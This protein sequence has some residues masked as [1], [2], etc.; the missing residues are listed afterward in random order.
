MVAAELTHRAPSASR[1]PARAFAYAY[2]G[3]WAATLSGW[4]ALELLG[5]GAQARARGLIGARLDA[6]VNPPPRIGH[7]LGLAAHNLPIAAWPLLLAP[8]GAHR[9]RTAR[10][11][12]DAL[13]AVV[14]I[15]NAAPVGAALAAYGA[16]LIAFVPQ[17]PMEWAA[18]ALGA[19]AWL[20]QRKRA[21]R[22]RQVL[23]V[24]GGIAALVAIAAALETVAVPHR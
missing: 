17:L 22:P 3:V 21:L 9:H 18:L 5:A 8:I 4:L 12:A 23:A 19:A 6:S 2:A 10:L 15:L 14:L 13:L 16:R 1:R 11:G 20:C 24:L 7:V